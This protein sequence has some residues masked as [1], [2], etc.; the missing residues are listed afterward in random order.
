MEAQGELQ[1]GL[2]DP[3]ILLG[4]Q[5]R[6]G[7]TLLSSILR[8]TPGHFQAFEL[9]IRKPSFATGL[10]GR[11]TRNIFRDLDLPA[12]EYDAIVRSTDCS[13]MNL[14]SWVGPKEDVSAEPLSGRETGHFEPE[15]RARAQLTTRLM[16]RVAEIHD[17]STWGFK[18]LGDIVYADVF[19]RIWP[20]AMF[21]LMIRDPRDQAMSVLK[22][23]EQRSARGQ[24]N[25]YDD[26]RQAARGWRDTIEQARHTMT[27]H[28]IPF[29]ETRYEDLVS[30]TASELVR[31][32]D[33]LNLDL[34]KGLDFHR[35]EFIDAHTQRFK[36]HD[37]LK[38]M[39]NAA[40]VGKWREA[41]SPQDLKAFIEVAGDL[42]TQL[43]YA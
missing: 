30:N 11:Y 31:L 14:G 40:S 3:C 10:D 41:L 20:K 9:H 27:R 35:R 28:K 39:V 34:S 18:I 19:A 32:S 23:N 17:A 43:D 4:G 12:T 21:I 15:L 24:Q 1:A 16:R 6:S 36:H 33:A 25:F 42:M 7:T 5:P 37:N 29:V 22:L 38:N 8:C 2:P 26:Y 13:E